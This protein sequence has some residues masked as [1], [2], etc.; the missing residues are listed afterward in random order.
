[1]LSADIPSGLDANTGNVHGKCV[2][3]DITVSFGF[4]KQGFYI[5]SGPAHCGE[6]I[7]SDIGFPLFF[8]K[9]DNEK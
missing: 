5:N 8:Y 3:S 7:V 9:G 2:K 4:A 6:I 1:M